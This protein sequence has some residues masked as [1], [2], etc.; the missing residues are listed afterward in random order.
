M[1]PGTHRSHQ[2]RLIVYGMLVVIAVHAAESPPQNQP[3]MTERSAVTIPFQSSHG[4]VLVSGRLNDSGPLRFLLDTGYS[5]TMLNG[6]L[7][8]SLNL[9]RAGQVTIAGIAGDEQADVFEGARF[10]FSGVAFTPRRI[11]AFPP[12]NSRRPRGRDG[13]L[14]SGFFKTFVVEIDPQA[15]TLRLHEP[16]SYTYAGKG[17]IIPLQFKTTTPFIEAR[18]NVPG[19][20][21]AVGRFEIDTG[22]DGGLC[23]GSDFVAAHQLEKSAGETEGSVRSG[24]GGGTR[25]RIGRVPQLQLGRLTIDQPLA[26]FFQDGS[27]VSESFAGHIGM[28]VL[29]HFKVVFDYSRQRMMLEKVP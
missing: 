8:H 14:G 15:K 5:M 26:N 10:D 22:C 25:T 11:A 28:D 23:L 6:E 1:K 21:P 2:I 29:R 19:R 24:V 17:E 18:I 7:A 12:R 9:R 16:K 4:R 3:P 20:Q 27:P 13:I